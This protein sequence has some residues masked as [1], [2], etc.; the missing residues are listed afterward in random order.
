MAVRGYKQKATLLHTMLR[1]A[2]V[3]SYPVII[4][5]ERGSVTSGTPAHNAFDHVILAVRLPDDLHDPSLAA[6]MSH[7]MLGRLLFFDPTNVE[8][9]F[10]Q[11]GGYLQA[12][13][14]LLVTPRRAFRLR[15]ACIA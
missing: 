5:H 1:K 6:V 13:Y 3:E 15:I 7:P 9:P 11:I 10:G 14:G 12:N 8:T 2:R 4:N